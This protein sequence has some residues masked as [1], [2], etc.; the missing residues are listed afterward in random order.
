VVTR[1]DFAAAECSGSDRGD[2]YGV[3][4]CL[5]SHPRAWAT[6]SVLTELWATFSEPEAH[7]DFLL[8]DR[9]VRTRADVFLI[10]ATTEPPA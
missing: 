1:S 10:P 8:V 7:P 4:E 3:L 5:T 9:T 6:E 2:K